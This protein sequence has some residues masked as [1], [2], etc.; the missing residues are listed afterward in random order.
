MKRKIIRILRVSIKVILILLALIAAYF[1]IVII[2]NTRADYKPA[3]SDSLI[4]H[5]APNARMI[6]ENVS[7]ITWNI[8]YCG[9]GKEM[10]F[11]YEGGKA[12]RPGQDQYQLYLNGVFNHIASMDTVDFVLLQEVDFEAK[13][14]YKNRQ[15]SLFMKAL[16]KFFSVS[17]VN[18]KVPYVPFPIFNPM[19][20]VLSGLMSFSADIPAEARRVSYPSSYSWPM[21]VFF[22][23]RCF[24]ISR[25]V[26]ENGKQLVVINTHNSAFSDADDLRLVEMQFLKAY[27]L[28][29]YAKGNYVIA[30]GDWNQNPPSF[31][32][33]LIT[34]GDAT[35]LSGKPLSQDFMPDGWVWIWDPAWPSNRDVNIPYTKGSTNTTILDYYLVSPNVRI[36][37]VKTIPIGFDFSD[38][39][40]VYLNVSLLPDTPCCDSVAI[41]EFMKEKIAADKKKGKG[42]K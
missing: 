6:G 19:G 39:M 28:E 34:S 3:M 31:N 42:K 1:I 20:K 12:M 15:D 22:L 8:G 32:P 26:L 37:K 16:D 14:T 17:A 38:H 35:R 10:D 21:G 7:F 41:Y 29:E 2:V 5:E 33:A 25:F 23:D 13:R 18:Y 30:G 36:N 9:L 24:I 40:P 11:F 27:L 4:V